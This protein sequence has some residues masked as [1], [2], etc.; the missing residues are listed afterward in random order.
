MPM[1]FLD[2]RAKVICDE[3]KRES[4][5]QRVSIDQLEY[6]KGN[7]IR[8][9]DADRDETP[10]E[11]FDSRTMHWYGPDQHYWFCVRIPVPASFEGK[12]LWLHVRTQIED[13]DDAKNP[14][15]LL[16]A[17]GEAIQ[18]IDVNHRDV[19]I[20]RSARAGHE[21]RLDLQSYTGTLHSEFRLILEMREI[22]P[23][24]E[25]L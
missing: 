24:I 16:F 3:L 7:F 14:Q 4:V 15:F 12:P 22:D 6:K 18:G 21:Y 10:Y 23:E 25:G 17:D 11:P 13:W 1:F 19:L 9:E 2:K 20:T 8:P 5:R